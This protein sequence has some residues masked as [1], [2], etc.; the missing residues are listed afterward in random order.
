MPLESILHEYN[1]KPKIENSGPYAAEKV[2][3][4]IVA[5]AR[6]KCYATTIGR[7]ERL[8]RSNLMQEGGMDVV[9]KYCA[10]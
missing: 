8:K 2:W 3:G 4:Q 1:A 6:P 5:N 10:T 9:V 7:E